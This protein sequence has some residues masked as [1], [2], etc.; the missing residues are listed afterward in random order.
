M[1]KKIEFDMGRF[2]E[3]ATEITTEVKEAFQ[4]EHSNLQQQFKIRNILN[5][6]KMTNKDSNPR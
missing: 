6:K 1:S 3:R 2:S 4:E 5:A